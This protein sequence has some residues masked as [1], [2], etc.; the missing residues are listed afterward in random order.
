MAA[1]EFGEP[2]WGSVGADYLGGWSGWMLTVVRLLA[3]LKSVAVIVDV[4]I[5]VDCGGAG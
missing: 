2:P 5:L 3:T 1:H 4:V